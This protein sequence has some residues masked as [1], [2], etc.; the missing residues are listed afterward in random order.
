MQ[1]I[2]STPSD[3]EAASSALKKTRS[4]RFWSLR[5][6]LILIVFGLALILRLH[7]AQVLPT[8][9]DEPDYLRAAEV[10]A[11]HIAAGDFNGII[12]EQTNYE[13]PPM[14]K[15]VFGIIMYSDH[16]YTQVVRRTETNIRDHHQRMFSA[17]IGALTAAVVAL[18]SPLA[19]LLVA[20]NA[21]HIRY[22]SETMLEALPCL[23]SGLM[24]LILRRSGFNRDKY[25]WLAAIL[26]GLTAAGKYI[27]AVVGFAALI[28]LLS[29]DRRSWKFII[30]WIG[31]ALL[32]FYVADPALWPDPL[33]RL[34]ASLTFNIHYTTT[35]TVTSSGYSWFQPFVWLVTEPTSPPNHF[36]TYP[37]PLNALIAVL[38][39]SALP[40]LWRKE[41][42]LFWWIAVDLFFLLLWPTKW[43]QYI[44]ILTVPMALA[45]ALWLQYL[46]VFL[47]SKRHN[48][49]RQ[50][51]TLMW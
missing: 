41:R 38:T 33:S 6:G 10:Y 15:I 14:T 31:V 3:K 4:I 51:R 22:T 44:L 11:Q 27:Y 1:Q 32:A 29:R 8:D 39:L 18:V 26:L 7:A 20:F 36:H 23:F 16:D 12:N 42:L 9:N 45:A 46:C 47:F 5:G 43:S 30:A 48:I 19:G 40:W 21:W 50:L 13:H 49:F 28:W 37:L 2:V 35:T 17:I 25:F 34:W 24:L